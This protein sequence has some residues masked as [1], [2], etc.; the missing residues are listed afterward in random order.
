M[1]L[2]MPLILSVTSL[3]LGIGCG[4]TT[5]NREGGGGTAGSGTGGSPAGQGG[6]G[7]AAKGGSGA[8]GQGGV[9]AGA[10]AGGRGGGGAGTG[11]AVS[12]ISASDFPGRVVAAQCQVLVACGEAM[13]QASC[14]AS[15]LPKGPS[16]YPT[17][18]QDIASGKALYDGAQA[19]ICLAIYNNPMCTETWLARFNSQYAQSCSGVLTGI[20]P[21]TARSRP[22]PAATSSGLR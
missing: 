11:G 6:G 22:G 21:A 1:R 13:D 12:S 19:A 16:E 17:L 8:G 18:L 20:R 10:S 7:A 14:V 9:G 4:S 15:D 3:G 2:C 5:S